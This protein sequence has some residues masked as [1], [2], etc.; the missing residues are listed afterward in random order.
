MKIP[1]RAII[2]TPT[3]E[4]AKILL[5][6]LHTNGYKWSGGRYLTEGTEWDMYME[7]TC[8][9][10]E[11]GKLVCYCDVG[12]YEEHQED[13]YWPDDERL[14]FCT[15]NEFIALCYEDETYESINFEGIGD[16]I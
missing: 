11:P 12:W 15:V 7:E 10:L 5:D 3:S 2:R 8:Y 9:D 4:E 6:F 13:C 1:E 16:L 14:E